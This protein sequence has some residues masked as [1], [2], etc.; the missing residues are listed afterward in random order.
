MWPWAPSYFGNT[1]TATQ[2]YYW[3]HLR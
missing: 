2:L 3:Y 1:I